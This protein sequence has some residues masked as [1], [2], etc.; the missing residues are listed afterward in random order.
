MIDTI[1]NYIF[2]F[3]IYS[4]LG[5]VNEVIIGLIFQRKFINQGFIFGPFCT[6]Y[7]FG[8][9]I[10]TALLQFVTEWPAAVFAAGAILG[11]TVEYVAH[12][13]LERFYR[14]SR[15]DYAGRVLNINGRV[16]LINTLKFGLL[17]LF[18]VYIAQPY[19]E[20]VTDTLPRVIVDGVAL[21]VAVWFVGDVIAKFGRGNVSARNRKKFAAHH[22][23]TRAARRRRKLSI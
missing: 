12:W 14:M 3:F 20:S 8:G 1:A 17:V 22:T 6:V 9:V 7:G 18:A 4:F 15:W 2:W 19:L 5:W 11:A 13:L 16:C 10:T 23:A 21:V